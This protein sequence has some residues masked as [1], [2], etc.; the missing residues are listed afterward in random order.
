MATSDLGHICL[1]Q[2]WILNPLS[3]ASIE[4][5]FSQRQHQ[6][7]N[8]LSQN[9]NSK[10]AF[11]EER[12]FV[13]KTWITRR[14]HVCTYPPMQDLL[15]ST[16]CLAK[17]DWRDKGK[18]DTALTWTNSV[19]LKREKESNRYNS[20]WSVLSAMTE[21]RTIALGN[22]WK[23]SQSNEKKEAE[24]TLNTKKRASI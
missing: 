11:L 17:Q 15:S 3:K 22:M 13:L 5:E 2:G 12:E 4:P 6:V 21:G 23:E 1:Q 9:A 24:G 19:C 7:L 16:I 20:V 14:D 10:H 8:L 18:S